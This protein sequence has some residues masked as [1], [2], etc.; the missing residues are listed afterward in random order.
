MICTL[1][2][3]FYFYKECT[4]QHQEIDSFQV[5]IAYCG[6]HNA[7]YRACVLLKKWIVIE[8]V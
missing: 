4:Y 6:V 7:S 1:Q 8:N 2:L 5:D 3:N